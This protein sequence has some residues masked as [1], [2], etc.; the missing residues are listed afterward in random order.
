MPAP[1]PP[2][3]PAPPSHAV[4]PAIAAGHGHRAFEALGTYVHLATSDPAR[5]DTAAGVA[6][7]VLAEVDLACS[8]FRQDSDLSRVN[9]AAGSWV[10]VSPLLVAAVR[11]ALDAAV[12]TDGLVDPCLGTRMTYLGYDADLRVVQARPD[13][14]WSPAGRDRPHPVDAWQ[15][16]RVDDG[17]VRV[18]EGVALDLGATAKAWAA[19]LI[20]H[21]VADRC[22]RGVVVS[23]GGDVSALADDTTPSW[24]VT[25]TELRG[26]GPGTTV[27]MGGGG[28]ATSST[29][30]RRWRAAGSERHHLLDPRTGLPVDG[31]WRTVTATGPSSVAANVATTAALVLGRRAVPWLE[32]RRV[33]ARLV[34][35]DGRVV[36]TGHWPVE[37]S[38]TDLLNLEL[39]LP[40][41]PA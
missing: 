3:P 31:P 36:H 4:R 37:P 24:P 5:L 40:E 8:R 9:A 27:W 23:V 25:V 18:P 14:T 17:A 29:V 19:D 28:L 35:R 16:L 30:V 20:A 15:E 21:T 1:N 38:G 33:D 41:D 22:G 10:E 2:V 34:D 7:Q 13:H 6:R 12:D 39:T 11:I 32:A 26:R